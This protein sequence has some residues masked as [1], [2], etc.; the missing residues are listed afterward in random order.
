MKLSNEIITVLDYLCQ[1]FGMAIDWTSENVLP[2]IQELFARY[3]SYEIATSI[4][5]M[6]LIPA[7]TLIISIPL[8]VFN[9]KANME[10]W[11]E[12]WDY[13]YFPA[14]G[15]TISWILFGIMSVASIIVICTQVIDIIECCILPEKVILDYLSTALN[16]G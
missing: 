15:A 13:D 10:K 14:W 3:I 8:T 6:I 2:Y 16:K 7:I 1:K 9:I 4:A 12:H 11:N 5:W